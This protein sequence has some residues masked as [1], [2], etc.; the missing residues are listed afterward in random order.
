M[1]VDYKDY[2]KILGVDKNAS[3]KDIQKAYRKL[4]RKFHPDV[5]PDDKAAEEKFKELSEANEVLSDPEK[6]KRYD[7]LGRSY[8]QYGR[9]R[10]ATSGPM[11]AAG[12]DGRRAQYRTM[13]EEDLEDLFGGV[14]PFSDFFETF[15]G[16]GASNATR[17]QTRRTGR[18]Q[19]D[20]YAPAGQ[21]AEA[22]VDVTLA[23]AYQ[24]VT[25]VFELTEPNGSTRRVEVKIPAG[26]D[27][28]TRI[29]LQGESGQGDLYLRVHVLPDPHFTRQ[30]TTLRTRVDVPLATAILGGEVHVP[31]PDGRQML[32]RIPAGTTNG[33]SF[34]LRGQGM[35]ALGEPDRRGDLYAEVNVELPTHLNAEQRR[36]FEAF[37]HSM[38]YA[39]KGTKGEGRSSHG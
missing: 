32:L 21:D 11:G 14:S 9:R 37:A 16:S 19:R 30:G 38:G 15:F 17:G 34:R 25:R 27:E 36:L 33:K 12:G 28:G 24:G 2:Y 23:E 20:T 39:N 10:P 6:R 13:S 3:Q 35:P 18:A 7:E 31:T 8:Q 4:A 29:R 22:E 5:N 26:V 1:A